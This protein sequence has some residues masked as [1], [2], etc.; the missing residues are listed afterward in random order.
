MYVDIIFLFVPTV[1]VQ[2]VRV[3]LCIAVMVLY[4]SCYLNDMSLI[5]AY[6]G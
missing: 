6:S 1:H 2:A 4:L 5:A 3:I